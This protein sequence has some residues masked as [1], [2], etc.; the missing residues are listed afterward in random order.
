MISWKEILAR[1]KPTPSQNDSLLRN[2]SGFLTWGTN[3]LFKLY[4]LKKKKKK[5]KKGFWEAIST[6]APR[7]FQTGKEVEIVVSRATMSPF[8]WKF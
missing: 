8:K 7:S 3:F 4:I 2:F 5:K 6:A 1:N